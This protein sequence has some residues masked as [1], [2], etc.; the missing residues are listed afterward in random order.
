MGINDFRIVRKMMMGELH[1][2]IERVD[3]Y[4]AIPKDVN[5]GDYIKY[6]KWLEAGN[7]PEI[8]VVPT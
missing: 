7:V 3:P 8:F 6:L 4:G 2:Q 1:D 5:N